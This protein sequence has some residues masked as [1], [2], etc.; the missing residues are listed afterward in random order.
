MGEGLGGVGRWGGRLPAGGTGLA[1]L[2]GIGDVVGVAPP[3]ER[4]RGRRY[5]ISRETDRHRTKRGAGQAQL[6]Q[7]QQKEAHN[8][9]TEAYSYSLKVK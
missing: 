9:E 6:L 3:G 1:V 4:G 8:K 5:G 7:L 2:E